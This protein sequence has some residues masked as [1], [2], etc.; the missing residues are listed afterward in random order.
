MKITNIETIEVRIPYTAGSASQTSAWGGKEWLTADALL[1]KVSTD[2]GLTGWG[3][4]FGY[5]VIPATRVVLNE[6]VAPICIG[7]DAD[8]IG[9]LMLDLYRKL[10]IFGRGGPV[11]YALSGLDMA[12]WDIAGKAAGQALHRMLGGKRRDQ[13]NAYASLVRYVEPD[14]VASNV[15]RACDLGFRGIKLHEITVPAVAS[16]RQAAG[17]DVAIMLDVNCPWTCDEAIEM[18]RQLR[19][20]DLAW[21]EEPVWPPEDHA[22]LAIIR[23]QGGIPIAAGENAAT[24]QQYR[25]LFEAGALDVVQPSPAKSGGVSGLRDVFA[26]AG[27]FGVRVVPHSFYEGPGLLSAIHCCAALASEPLVEWRFFDC[28]ARLYGDDVVPAGGKFVVPDAPGLG[29]EPDPDVIERY[30]VS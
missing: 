2:S 3:E 11:I 28:E 6:L 23:E 9:S 25:H 14:Q 5:N 12:L 18:A 27:E 4:A 13:V 24:L 1:V 30:R 19:Q 8:D 15:A 22:S 21:L 10:H 16:A 29:R 20:Y 7:T 17:P 26:L